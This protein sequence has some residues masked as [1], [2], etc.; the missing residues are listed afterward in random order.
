[1]NKLLNIF[2]FLLYPVLLFAQTDSTNTDYLF[3]LSLDELLNLTIK[4][5]DKS[6]QKVIDI[7]ASIIIIDRKEI[8][9]AGYRNLEE[10]LE[11]VPGLVKIDDKYWLGGMNYSIRGNYTAGSF[12]DM[13]ILVNGVPQRED[14][15]DSYNL[16]GIRV[17]IEVIERIEI[18]KGPLSV[19]YGSGAFM[20]VI[21]IITQE[22]TN[23]TSLAQASYGTAQSKNAVFSL[24]KSVEDLSFQIIGSWY[25]DKREG[26]ELGDMATLIYK[27]VT[28]Y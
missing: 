8:E 11:N 4:S 27:N 23:N 6:E 2:I 1:M 14:Y 26:A 16:A 3:D 10:V 21:N 15:Y 22:E 20:G 5:A 28:K 19:T 24:S 25:D 18:V 9:A 7:P 13:I 17:P 12:N